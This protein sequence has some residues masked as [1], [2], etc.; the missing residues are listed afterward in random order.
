LDHIPLD[1]DWEVH[2]FGSKGCSISLCHLANS[3]L[4]IT[5]RHDFAKE[6]NK[7][8]QENNP[9]VFL[10]RQ[11]IGHYN[12]GKMDFAQSTN[13]KYHTEVPNNITTN[14]TNTSD[15]THMHQ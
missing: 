7:I 12:G 14:N 5:C 15:I 10:L 3:A 2:N 6:T 13:R 8:C 4:W 11:K 9:K 1:N